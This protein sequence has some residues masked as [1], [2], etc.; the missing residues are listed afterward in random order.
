MSA[1]SFE[2]V[3]SSTRPGVAK[4]DAIL[5][6]DGVHRQFGGLIAVDVEHVEIREYLHRFAPA[7]VADRPAQ[8][9]VDPVELVEPYRAA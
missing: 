4:P 6:A 2:G 9:R 3:S 1:E 7:G 8:H 5:V